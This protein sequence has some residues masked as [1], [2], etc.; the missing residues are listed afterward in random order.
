[1]DRSSTVD[2]TVDISESSRLWHRRLAASQRGGREALERSPRGRIA[3]G[4]V[5]H[6]R[7]PTAGD[8]QR[9]HPPTPPRLAKASR[10]DS[11]SFCIALCFGSGLAP[12]AVNFYRFH[13]FDARTATR[14]AERRASDRQK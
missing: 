11:T 3:A 1:M 6:V 8:Y 4:A 14:Q 10:R 12:I 9:L 13:Q 7:W 2:I 5:G